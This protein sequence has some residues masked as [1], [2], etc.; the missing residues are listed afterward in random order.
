MYSIFTYI[1]LTFMVNVGKDTIHGSYGWAIYY[2]SLTWI[3]RPFWV[4][5]YFSLLFGET[6]KCREI[7]LR[8]F[9][10]RSPHR[11]S[12]ACWTKIEDPNRTIW[13]S[14]CRGRTV[15]HNA[16]Q[17][18]KTQDVFWASL[19]DFETKTPWICLA[20][21]HGTSAQKYSPKWIQ[22]AGFMVESVKNRQEKNQEIH[23][24]CMC[25][26]LRNFKHYLLVDCCCMDKATCR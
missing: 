4:R 25:H 9:P 13:S 7:K 2:K 15:K 8:F 23:L 3:V 17:G 24:G 26:L 14:A 6:L 12:S 5:T 10:H 16:P 18:K 20:T 19:V 21:M 11:S 22:V 1:W